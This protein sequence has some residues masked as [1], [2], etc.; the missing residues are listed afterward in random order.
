MNE[1]D[2]K[3]SN[4]KTISLRGGNGGSVRMNL[5]HGR[6]KSVLIETKRKKIILPNKTNL[7]QNQKES[8]SKKIESILTPNQKVI[9]D[10][11]ID[12]RK[13]AI[14]AAREREIIIK[15]KQEELQKEKTLEA[16]TTNESKSIEAQ[17]IVSD[18]I[19]EIK[20]VSE[21]QTQKIKNKTDSKFEGR[22]EEIIS[23]KKFR[24]DEELK[25]VKP[26]KVYCDRMRSGKLTINQSLSDLCTSLSLSLYH[27]IAL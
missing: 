9:S 15:E 17:E 8:D 7:S 10:E 24:K 1:N 19:K 13:K 3:K 22:S 14:E 12:R 18:T 20:K 6:S 2:K 16:Q 26:S 4:S 11:Q 21:E 23:S 25:E 27:S 5:S